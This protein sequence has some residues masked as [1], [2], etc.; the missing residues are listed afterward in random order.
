[1]GFSTVIGSIAFM[2]I[3]VSM[4][5]FV[6]TVQKNL[7][8]QTQEQTAASERERTQDGTTINIAS[9][10]YA[11]DVVVDWT[12]TTY[13]DFTAG[14]LASTTVVSPGT[15]VLIG[16]AYTSN[17]TWTSSVF[18]TGATGTNY[19]SISWTAVLPS[20]AALDFSGQR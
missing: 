11:Q 5:V 13:S 6:V 1:M 19:T 20:G 16:P 7:T 8:L 17:G 9:A 18:D 4:L 12:T 14:T 2:F 10:S 3:V 15:L